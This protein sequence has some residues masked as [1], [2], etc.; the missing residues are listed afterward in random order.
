MVEVGDVFEDDGLALSLGKSRNPLPQFCV[1]P[2]GECARGGRADGVGAGETGGVV[3]RR[4]AT[5][6]AM[7]IHRTVARDREQPTADV[8]RVGARIGRECLHPRLLG[9]V[10]AI[11]RSGQ[12]V[13]ESGDITP[14]RVDD[15][16]EGWPGHDE[17][18]VGVGSV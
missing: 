6:A 18:T 17:S 10:V 4:R 3:M 16:L 12:G 1:R 2:L 9:H 11:G 13:R 7:D 14:V 8:S 5:R 15:C